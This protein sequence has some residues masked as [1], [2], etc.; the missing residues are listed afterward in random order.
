MEVL[1][2]HCAGLDVHKDTVVACARHALDGT[3]KRE[4]RT[5]K[6]ITKDLLALSEWLA[7]EGCSQIVME[8]TGVYWKPVWHIL[9]DGDFELT[10]ANSAHVKNV[11]GRKTDVNDA[12]W[13]ADLLAHGLVRGSFVPDAQTQEQRGLLRTRKQ[14]VRERTSHVQRLQKTLED[15]NI[16]LDSVIADIIGLSGRSMIEALIGGETDP[17]RLAALAHRRIKAPAEV[18]R[19]A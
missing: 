5:F 6:T 17:D 9:S 15:A 4:V 3:V 18:L 11:P 7:S 13:L 1:H 8:A 19:E 2:P 10:L 16:K 12:T 14:L